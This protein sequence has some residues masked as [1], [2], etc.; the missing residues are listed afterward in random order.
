MKKLFLTLFAITAALTGFAQTN[1]AVGHPS[2][3]SSG[4]AGEGND[5]NTGTRWEST[6]SDPQTWQVDLEEAQTFNTIR[7]IWEGAYSSTFQ[8]IAG[9]EVGDDGYVVNGTTIYSIEGQTLSG[10]FPYTQIIHLDAPVTAR[11]VKFNGTARGTGY[12]HSFWEFEIMNVEEEMV[13]TTLT[14]SAEKTNLVVG[15]FRVTALTPEE[16]DVLIEAVEAY[17]KWK[18]S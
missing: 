16:N 11:Y 4:N 3:A 7:I 17:Q 10:P 6:H 1:L 9:D 12:G 8:I 15:Y 2:I 13:V 14:V 18:M 5:G